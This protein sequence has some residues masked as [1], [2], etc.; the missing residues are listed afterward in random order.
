MTPLYGHF[1]PYV[2]DLLV[3][4]HRLHFLPSNISENGILRVQEEKSD[5]CQPILRALPV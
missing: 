3:G 2:A 1:P 4:M 5:I